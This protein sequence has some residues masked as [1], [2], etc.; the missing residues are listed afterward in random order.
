LEQEGVIEGEENLKKYI[1]KYYKGLF[2]KTENNNF[3]LD[4]D[5]SQVTE[6]ENRALTEEFT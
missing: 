2:G 1:T 3:S 4:E 6:E 5:I